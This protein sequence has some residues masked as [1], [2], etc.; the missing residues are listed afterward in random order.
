MPREHQGKR[1]S[2]RSRPDWINRQPMAGS[3]TGLVGGAL[4][5]GVGHASTVRPDPSILGV[6]GERGSHHESCFRLG[7]TVLASSRLLPLAVDQMGETPPR[8][9]PWRARFSETTSWSLSQRIWPAAG[10]RRAAGPSSVRRDIFVSRDLVH[11]SLELNQSARVS[12]SIW[13][14]PGGQSTPLAVMPAS[15]ALV[16]RGDCGCGWGTSSA[17]RQRRLRT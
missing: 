3:G 6:V 13:S 16:A 8:E 7:L 17:A 14:A 9:W 1:R 2:Q 11:V 15:A 10:Q 12:H 5:A 4:A